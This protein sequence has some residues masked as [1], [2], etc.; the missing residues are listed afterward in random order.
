METGMCECQG[1]LR[2]SLHDP[3]MAVAGVEHGNARGKIDVTP[4]IDV[5]QLGIL[6][7]G[8]INAPAPHAGGHRRRF[9][10]FQLI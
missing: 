2:H 10:R 3:R 7:L 6:R 1:L 5:P 9:A 4:S 8:D